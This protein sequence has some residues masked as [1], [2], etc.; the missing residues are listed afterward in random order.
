[1]NKLHTLIIALIL[2][3]SL[4][5]QNLQTVNPNTGIS[6]HTLALSLT[7]QNTHFNQGS[8]TIWFSVGS[9]TA[10]SMTNPTATSSSVISGNVS[11]P[12]GTPNGV[13]N[14]NAHNNTDGIMT[15]YNAFIVSASSAQIISVAP[16]NGN[17][18]QTLSLSLSCQNANFSSGTNTQVWF[19]QGS[20]TMMGTNTT[21]LS[22][23]LIN[24]DLY[25]SQTAP[26]GVYNSLASNS[27]DGTLMKASSFTVNNY[28]PAV[29]NVY[30]NISK[31]GKTID[32]L[33]ESNGSSYN[34][35]FY[36][37]KANEIIP[38]TMNSTYIMG[39]GIYGAAS[40]PAS[41]SL[42]IYDLVIIDNSN[43]YKI[44]NALTLVAPTLPSID[45]AVVET[46]NYHVLDVYGDQTH[47]TSNN[48]NVIVDSAYLWFPNDSVVV[49]NDTHLKVYGFF[50][51]MGVKNYDPLQSWVKIINP[52]DDT[53]SYPFISY[54]T[55][56][57]GDDLGTF[58]NIRY[59]P[60]PTSDIV[61]IQSEEFKGNTVFI[62]VF[63]PDG[64]LLLSHKFAIGEPINIDL[65][66]YPSGLY[67]IRISSQQKT[68]T[69]SVIRR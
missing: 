22:N 31:P 5:S 13:Y 33:I 41:A 30:P 65:K 43:T 1:M 50:L 19:S 35:Q 9:T 6:G 40:I 68:K 7:G 54:Y 38:I 62:E 23:N 21:V 15:M 58:N 60:N 66:S 2:S 26:S 11:I 4:M 61:R 18:G 53:L 69:L 14:V 25:I 51:M 55:G 56:S 34:A 3:T 67:N 29:S 36:Y 16:N 27:I 20:Y 46:T 24:T 39:Y 32:V 17:H 47:F 8:N 28:I 59:F 44:S 45:S 63:S 12:Y 42:G 57:I 52:I 64:K 10:F 48:L 49:I 37:Q